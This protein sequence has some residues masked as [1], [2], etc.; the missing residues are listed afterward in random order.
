MVDNNEIRKVLNVAGACHGIE[1]K[2]VEDTVGFGAVV[3][4]SKLTKS[5]QLANLGDIGAKF[6]WDTSLCKNYFT[7]SPETGTIP[8]HEDVYFDITFH[9]NV[10]DNDIR[11]NKVKC[12]IH[13]SE[14]L[15]INL[16]GKCIDQPKDSI[17]EL[18]FETV[19]RTPT[20]KKVTVKNP[21]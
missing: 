10:V 1:L 4:N 14:P 3:L 2:L 19:V 18:R 15:Y 7:I 6:V 11:F 21:T 17:Q 20:T 8:A 5:V 16:L 13:G 12:S 9:P